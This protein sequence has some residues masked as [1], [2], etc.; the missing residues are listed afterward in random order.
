[1]PMQFSESSIDDHEQ[2]QARLARFGR[3]LASVTLGYIGIVSA[4]SLYVVGG[5]F[6]RG[7]IPLLVA[8]AAFVALWALLRGAPRSQRFVRIVEL[9]TLFVGTAAFS[10]TALVLDLTASPDMMVRTGVSYI[11][12]VYAVYV[13]STAKRTLVVASLMT[14]PLL[15]CIF[16]AFSSWDPALHD[17]PAAI[18]P[19][20]KAGDMAYTATAVSAG[21]WAIVVSVPA[22]LRSPR[23]HKPWRAV[24][25]TG[26]RTP[27]SDRVRPRRIARHAIDAALLPESA[28]SS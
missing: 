20:G 24:V 19:K 11:L 21:L 25:R 6:N 17:P 8:G 23:S 4:T 26:V 27:V 12:L 15:G 28:G 7:S 16:I 18:W 5:G 3:V 22:C 9:S 2:R 1:M 10:T 13:P 14:L